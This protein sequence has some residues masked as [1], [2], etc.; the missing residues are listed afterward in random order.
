MGAAPRYYHTPALTAPSLARHWSGIAP[1]WIAAHGSNIVVI[2]D[3]LRNR[4]VASPA[5]VLDVKKA[6]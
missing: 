1:M 5:V 2:P 6:G 4:A 3:T